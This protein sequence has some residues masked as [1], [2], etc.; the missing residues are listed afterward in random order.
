MKLGH[1][2]ASYKALLM[3]MHAVGC[4]PWRQIRELKTLEICG[5]LAIAVLAVVQIG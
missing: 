4:A 1:V 5:T 2:Y 3:Y